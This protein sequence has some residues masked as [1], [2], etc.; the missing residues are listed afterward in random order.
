[1]EF[2]GTYFGTNRGGLGAMFEALV[3][4]EFFED[5]DEKSYNVLESCNISD[6]F[7]DDKEKSEEELCISQGFI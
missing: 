1:M 6:A 7:E 5:K 2:C 3:P 4:D